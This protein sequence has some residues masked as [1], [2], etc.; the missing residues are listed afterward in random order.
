MGLGPRLKLVVIQP[1]GQQLAAVASLLER[2]AIHPPRIARAF[3]LER[4]RWAV[5]AGIGGGATRPKECCGRPGLQG[6]G[7][8]Q[9][10]SGHPAGIQSAALPATPHC[11]SD[12]HAYFESGH[13]A[14]KVVLK[15]ARA[16]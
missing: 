2:R 10:R 14:G 9:C 12:A 11:Y 15:V 1:N 13:A 16:P 6:V 5:H 8:V 4:A 7:E 3:P